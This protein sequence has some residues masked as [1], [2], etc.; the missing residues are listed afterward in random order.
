VSAALLR[1]VEHVHGHLAWLST[2]ALYHPAILLHNGRRRV[3]G[4]ASAATLLVTATAAL[5][6]F[7]YPAY[8][9]VVKPVLFSSSPFI[10]NLF[11][12]KEHLGVG[13]LILSWAGLAFH[14]SANRRVADV[15]AA[16]LA[17]VAYVAAAAFATLAAVMGVIVAVHG[18][19]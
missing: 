10:G 8:R 14:L 12:R 19:F 9:Q 15:R 5:G 16:T 1:I 2:L 7:M 18:S 6:A 13:T 17:F 11:E 3:V 4:A